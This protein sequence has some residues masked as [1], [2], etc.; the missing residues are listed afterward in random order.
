MVSCI[1][2]PYNLVI[3]K[4]E[5][6]FRTKKSTNESL[7]T[8]SVISMNESQIEIWVERQVDRLD[9]RFM[10]NKITAEEYDVEIYNIYKQAEQ[11][12]DKQH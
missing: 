12:Y 10:N 4:L 2:K 8:L 3:K 5:L 11:L 1:K 6:F 7:S 9:K